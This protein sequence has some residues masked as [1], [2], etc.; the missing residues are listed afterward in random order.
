MGPRSSALMCGYT[1][2]HRLLE[3]TLADLKNKEVFKIIIPLVLIKCVLC[4]FLNQK[5]CEIKLHYVLSSS[6]KN[7]GRSY[8]HT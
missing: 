1:D 2:Y 6:M 5:N 4:F 3:S 7:Q 8:T